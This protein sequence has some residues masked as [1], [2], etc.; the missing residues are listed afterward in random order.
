M[1]TLDLTPQDTAAARFAGRLVALLRADQLELCEHL[2]TEPRPVVAIWF[3]GHAVLR[4]GACAAVAA[5]H[6]VQRC[7]R[8]ASTAGGLLAARLQ[9]GQVGVV[10]VICE[11]C[12]TQTAGAP[13]D[14]REA[15]DEVGT[16]LRRLL[17]R[18]SAT[19]TWQ[20]PA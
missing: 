10:A 18:R 4:C 5:G 14:E 19:P 20:G 1:K 15:I 13:Y 17:S 9:V 8:C 3:P 11:P 12:A 16:A 2:P 6:L 7:A